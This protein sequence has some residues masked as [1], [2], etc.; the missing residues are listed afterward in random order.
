MNNVKL[1][2][3]VETCRVKSEHVVRKKDK[4]F[5]NKMQRQVQI[6]LNIQ[7]ETNW[8]LLDA[9]KAARMELIPDFNSHK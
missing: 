4:Y 8:D 9:N 2:E 5:S 6:P 1:R 7:E 3:L